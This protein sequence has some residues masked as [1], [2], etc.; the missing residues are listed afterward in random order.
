MADSPPRTDPPGRRA[1]DAAPGEGARVP[2]QGDGTGGFTVAPSPWGD[3]VPWWSSEGR[4][5]TGPQRV[6]D[7]SGPQPVPSDGSGPLRALP[8][9]TG[10]HRMP[11]NGTGPHRRPNGTGP[12][13]P[14]PDVPRRRG[15]GMLLGAGA[16]AVLL[17]VLVAG[18]LLLRSGDATGR[19]SEGRTRTATAF[20]S[21]RTIVAGATAGGLRRESLPPRVS[22]AYPFVMGG[23]EAGGLPVA[24]QG[25]AVYGEG[26]D[27]VLDVLF[28]GGTGRVDDP[29]AFLQR[30]RPT[31]FITGQNANPG[32]AG[33]KAACGTFAVLGAVHTY[34]AW[35]TG[36]SYGVV[37]SNVAS[38]QPRY[39]VMSALMRRIRGDI[40]QPR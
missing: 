19:T 6:A 28:A 29:A 27:G 2:Q 15:T 12:L 7:P 24:P 4:A 25:A 21:S 36:D 32:Q 5:G 30:I 22:V 16:G 40:E 14:V 33:G 10:P 17:V 20:E 1:A 3:A 26:R 18:V 13:P 37:A 23:V 35:A 31:T 34:C 11:P 38:Q 39:A 9:G 8:D